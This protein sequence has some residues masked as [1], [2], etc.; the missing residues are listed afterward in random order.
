M[1]PLKT[2]L[3]FTTGQFCLSVAYD[4]TWVHLAHLF[5]P[6]P[7][8]PEVLAHSLLYGGPVAISVAFIL[9]ALRVGF[10]QGSNRKSSLYLWLIAMVAI[11]IMIQVIAFALVMMVTCFVFHDCF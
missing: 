9:G 1:H 8:L 4:A 7:A 6:G 10:W 3:W 11:S 2:V 5:Y